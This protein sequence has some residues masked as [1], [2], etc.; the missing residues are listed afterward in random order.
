MP[1]KPG[2]WNLVTANE[3]D[4]NKLR[5]LSQN[6]A[7]IGDEEH[8]CSEGVLL[9]WLLTQMNVQG[10]Q[11]VFENNSTPTG[12][13]PVL[14]WTQNGGTLPVNATAATV[15]VYQNG[16]KL[17]ETLDYTISGSS[18]TII[19]THAQGMTYEVIAWA[20]GT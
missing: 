8:V 3:L 6:L 11:Q 2:Q 12:G 18:I 1:V 17:I 5:L 4:G 10:F 13:T 15:F 20:K 7:D 19:T 9:Q 16:R 14:T